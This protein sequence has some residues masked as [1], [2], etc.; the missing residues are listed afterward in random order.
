MAGYSP[1]IRY[2][3]Q[4]SSVTELSFV[5]NLSTIEITNILTTDIQVLHSN[6][7]W[8][9]ADSAAR[10]T[11]RYC[12]DVS[13]FEPRLRQDFL[14]STPVKIGTGFHPSSCTTGN[15]AS[16]RR[17]S[18]RDLALTNPVPTECQGQSMCTATHPRTLYARMEY[19]GDTQRLPN[20][21]FQSCITELLRGVFRSGIQ[22]R[23]NYTYNREYALVL[24]RLWNSIG[25]IFSFKFGLTSYLSCT[26]HEVR[27][28]IVF[29]A[30]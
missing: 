12:L 14:L 16:S 1:F 2:R 13:G 20:N 19:Y 5:N 17:Q 24:F 9:G 18:A 23:K 6:L 30:T 15:R 11:S 4:L 22:Q 21:C 25:G 27:Q 7:G 8:R 29:H 26:S 3:S 10:T 28:Y